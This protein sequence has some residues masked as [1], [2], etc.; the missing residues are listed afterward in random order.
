MP[1]RYFREKLFDLKQGK[2][3]DVQDIVD[4]VRTLNKKLIVLGENEAINR[5]VLKEQ[6]K[7]Q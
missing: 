2:Y 4:K 6:I 1:K 7:G 3:E 5:F